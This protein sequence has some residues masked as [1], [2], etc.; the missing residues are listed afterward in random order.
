MLRSAK[1]WKNALFLTIKYHNSG[2]GHENYL[3]DPNFFHLLFL[4]YLL[5]IFISEFENTENSFSSLL[6]RSI[7]VCKIPQFFS[8]SN[9]F[10]QLIILF[11]KVDTL[12]LLKIYIMFCLPPEAKYPFFWLQLMDYTGGWRKFHTELVCFFITCLVIK[13]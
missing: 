11:Q 3:N 7:L 10:G 12:W 4:L 9:W 13:K 2:R 5:V 6:R 8:K 1:N